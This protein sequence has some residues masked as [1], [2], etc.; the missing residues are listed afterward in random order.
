MIQKQ[1]I[2]KAGFVKS[3]KYFSLFQLKNTLTSCK[4]EKLNI[5]D[6]AVQIVYLILKI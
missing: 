1:T 3:Q 2:F 4:N 5:I 6:K